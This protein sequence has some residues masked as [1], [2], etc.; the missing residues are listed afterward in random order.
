VY[1]GPGE[2]D[3]WGGKREQ[4]STPEFVRDLLA[5]LEAS[6]LSGEAMYTASLAVPQSVIFNLEEHANLQS[7]LDQL[8]PLATS[9]QIIYVTYSQVVRIWQTEYG[10]RPNI[11]LGR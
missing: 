3:N 1:I 2:Y 6:T 10:A 8:A 9:G 11:Y 5:Q 7:M 4:R